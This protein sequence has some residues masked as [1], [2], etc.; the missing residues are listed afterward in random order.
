MLCPPEA[1]LHYLSDL[2]LFGL[3]QFLTAKIRQIFVSIPHPVDQE[4]M[5]LVEFRIQDLCA[6]LPQSSVPP[7][8]GI[9]YS[10]LDGP[11]PVM[12]TFHPPE[13]EQKNV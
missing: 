11:L 8:D 3:E 7:K 13:V 9:E 1:F 6:T 4:V 12:T 10:G 5:S 2:P